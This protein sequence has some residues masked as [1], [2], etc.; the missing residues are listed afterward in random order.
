MDAKLGGENNFDY[1]KLNLNEVVHALD[2]KVLSC[3]KSIDSDENLVFSGVATDSRNVKKDFIFFPL[4]GTQDGHNY[5][6]QAVGN[7]A[8]VIFVTE[9][10]ANFHGEKIKSLVSEKLTII[11]VSHTMYALQNLAALYV[12]KFPCNLLLYLLKE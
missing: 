12:S 10:F 2:G 1:I 9:F 8:S 11:A 7:G 6:D 4:V 3:G 5:I